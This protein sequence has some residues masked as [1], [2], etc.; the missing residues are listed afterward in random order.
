MEGWKLVAARRALAQMVNTLND[1]DRFA[2]FAFADQI[3]SPPQ[4]AGTQLVPASNRHRYWAVE[5]LHKIE[6]RGG[7]EIYQPLDLAAHILSGRESQRDRILVLVTDGQVTNEHQILRGLGER[8]RHLR[9]FALGIDK[10]VNEGFLKQFAGLGNG[11]CELVESEQ[12][13]E[14]VTEHVH[15]RIANPVLTELRLEADG[16]EIVPDSIVPG[17]LPD[18]FRSAA[19]CVWG[20]YR[21]SPEGALVVQARDAEGKPWFATAPA[22]RSHNPAIAPI[23]ARGRVRELEDQFS[24]ACAAPKGYS[25]FAVVPSR[26]LI[27]QQILK[28]SLRFGVLCRFNS[29]VAVDRVK[30]VNP[31]GLAQ[32]VT[33]TV[34][35]PDGWPSSEAVSYFDRLE[36]IAE[37]A[38]GTVYNCPPDQEDEDGATPAAPMSAEEEWLALNRSHPERGGWPPPVHKRLVTPTSPGPKGGTSARRRAWFWLMLGMLAL[39]LGGALW[40]ILRYL[41]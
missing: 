30:V 10:A 2:V 38:F 7:T 15:R 13:L 31:D 23:W 16:F 8:V 28:I 12:R 3:E 32:P 21:G 4:L 20:R 19:L 14:E 34:E 29:F 39:M 25:P 26:E 37:G 9:I 36:R 40:C 18:L 17:R 22:R 35:M 1:Q 33:Q 6:A 24:I 11:S 5:Y 27:E 41:A